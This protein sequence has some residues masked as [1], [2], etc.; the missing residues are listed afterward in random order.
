MYLHDTYSVYD[1]TTSIIIAANFRRVKCA[2]G[3]KVLCNGSR[4]RTTI[5]YVVIKPDSR[6]DSTAIRDHI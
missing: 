6:P 1:E 4:M 3:K 5:Q 2:F